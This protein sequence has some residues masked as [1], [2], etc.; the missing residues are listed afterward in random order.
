MRLVLASA[1]PTR[2]RMLEDAGVAFEVRTGS[3]DEEAAKARLR[4]QGLNALEL[5]LALSEYKALDAPVETSDLVIGSD[6]T[7]EAPDGTMLDKPGSRDEA[8]A[9]LRLLSGRKHWLHSA[10]AVVEDGAKSWSGAESVE[11]SVRPL[12]ESFISAYLDREY[13]AVRG[14]VGGYRIEGFG[15]QLF[16]RITG[17]HFAIMGLPLLPLLGYLRERG[18]VPS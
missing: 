3:G 1:S 16:D 13:E 5:A 18:V 10:A 12:S 2:R 17:S 15:V 4:G 7:L 9:Q 8:A 14:N 11:L 6:Q